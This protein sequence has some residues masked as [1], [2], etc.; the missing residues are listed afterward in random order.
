LREDGA[1]SVTEDDIVDQ[2]WQITPITHPNPTLAADIAAAIKNPGFGHIFSDH[3][4]TVQWSEDQG[5]HDATIGERKPFLIDPAA[6][7]L[8]YAQEIFEGLKAYKT[9]DGAITLFRPEQNARR[10]MKSAERL[11]MPAVPEALFLQ[12]VETLVRTDRAWIPDGDGSLYIRPFMF[13]SEVFLGVRPSHRYVF[14]VIASPAGPYFKGGQSAITVWAT[15]TFT[16]ASAGGTGAAKCGGN[17]ANS[18]L[19]QAEAT[20]NGCDQVVFLDA[21][22]HRWVEELGGMNVFFVMDDGRLV[23]PPLAGTILPGVTRASVIELAR[24]DGLVVEERTYAFDQWRD[25]AKAGRV[26]EVFACGTAAVISAIGTVRHS[27]GEFT[28]GDG[29]TGP[30][31]QR[32]HTVLTG[33]QR[34]RIK[35]QHGWVHVVV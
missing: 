24:E 25:D 2:D 30:V 6:A 26:K 16:R 8:H 31:T 33:I 12:A 11:A 32:I 7:V 35:D 9:A 34:G 14:C 23:T 28:I 5:W 1:Q 13:A 27:G 19:A 18:L 3:M 21:A 29:K 22:E 15:D 20:R 4:V 17:Y 10:F